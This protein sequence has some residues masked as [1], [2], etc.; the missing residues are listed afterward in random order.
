MKPKV[1]RSPRS[2]P[3]TVIGTGL[4][5]LD[6]VVNE[7]R[8][9]G[10]HLWA[11]G[12]CGNVLAVLSFLGWRAFPIAR[13]GNDS[14][15]EFVKKDLAQCKVRLDFTSLE[16]RARVPIIIQH[17]TQRK[18]GLPFHR[19]SWNC[20]SCGGWL[21]PYRAVLESAAQ[22]ILPRIEHA[23]VFFFDRVSRAA[24]TLAQKSAADGALVVFEPSCS[25]DR[26]QFQEALKI[27]HVLKYSHERSGNL[28]PLLARVKQQPLLEIETLGADGLRF[29]G[30]LMGKN[31]VAWQRLDAYELKEFRDPSGA[32]DWCTAGIIHK[33][34]QGGWET[35][36][37]V[38][39]RKLLDT[40]VFSQALAAWAC[41]YEG[42]R[43]GM[44]HSD[45]KTLFQEVEWIINGKAGNLPR[46][47]TPSQI[48][49]SVF[50][51]LCIDCDQKVRKASTTPKNSR[52]VE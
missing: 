12:T 28:K 49:T 34:G 52:N 32:G 19:F 45:Q 46:P 20:P 33:L 3:S 23:H 11:G 14:A 10:P 29:R 27:A 40:L 37:R 9:N 38:T 25:Q 2:G 44:Y 51:G 47:D 43:G 4:V 18:S 8:Q 22:E 30:Q 21:P 26:K 5:A 6:V 1:S 24:L 41:R 7:K 16:P 39:R 31:S 17:L 15:S 35:F 50:K 42:A 48:V 13:L 36:R